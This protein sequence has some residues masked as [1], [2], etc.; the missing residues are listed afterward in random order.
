MGNDKGIGKDFAVC[1][2]RPES[3]HCPI[4]FCLLFISSS[5][6]HLS[7]SRMLTHSSPEI[8][9]YINSSN[10]QSFISELWSSEW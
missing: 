7:S 1:V 2:L 4:T 6:S 9:F 5:P 10:E 8:K 3:D